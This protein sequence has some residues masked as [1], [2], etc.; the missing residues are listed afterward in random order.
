VALD[1]LA[2]NLARTRRRARKAGVAG[3]VAGVRAD[4]HGLPFADACFDLVVA[5]SVLAFCDAPRVAAEIGRVLKPGG[6]LGANEMTLLQPPPAELQHLLTGVLGM[7]VFQETEWR[8]LLDSA[9]LTPVHSIV[10]KLSLWEQAAS[11][12]QVDGVAGYLAALVKGLANLR[13]SRVFINRQMLRAA[14]Q[15]MPLVGYDLFVGQKSPS[16]R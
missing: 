16:S 4:A 11:H 6:L 8:S 13:L 2:A 9:G 10:R 12:L 1:G 7:Q 14:C 5:E 3:Q 15:F